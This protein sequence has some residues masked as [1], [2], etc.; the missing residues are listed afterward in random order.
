MHRN[1]RRRLEKDLLASLDSFPVV[2]LI[3]PRQCGK[4]TLAKMILEGK[5][6]VYIDLEKPSDRNKL[7]DPERF[8]ELNR[9]VLICLDEIHHVPEIFQVIR[10]MVDTNKRKGQFLI[11]GSA[12]P[13]LL[14]QSS[15]TLAGRI[16]YL[17]LAPFNLIETDP[18]SKH[19]NPTKIWLRGGFPDSY[20]AKN[21]AISFD[22]RESFVRTFIERDVPQMGFSIASRHIERFWTMCAHT[23][24]QVFNSSKLGDSLGVSYHTIRSYLDIL[25]QMFILRTLR[26]FESNTK[27]RL[28]KSPKVFIRDS[29]ILH[30]LLGIESNNDLLGHPVYGSSWEGFVIETIL[31]LFPR[32]KA[33]FYRTRS[34]SEVDLILERG[35]KKVAIECK[36]S[37]SPQVSAGFYNALED[38]GLKK[39]YIVSPVT[40]SY[41]INE[42]VDV[43]PLNQLMTLL[44]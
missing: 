5:R 40:D 20:L 23:H 8:F 16:R 36:A 25:D 14:K 26:P 42:T 11:L 18:I 3:G 7:R 17:E 38:L 44:K 43:I 37:T 31:A 15:E 32:W 4:S 34:G 33:S 35:T 29:G 28:I 13:K 24:G 9:D 30:A 19:P 39:A 1:I 22:W 12:S 2:A 6:A 10:S 21:D 27:K 41:P